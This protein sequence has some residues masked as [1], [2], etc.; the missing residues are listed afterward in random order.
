MTRDTT[1]EAYEEAKPKAPTQRELIEGFISAC[2]QTGATCD[3][4]EQIFKFTHQGASARVRELNQTNKIID[5]GDR[6]RTR[7]GRKAIVWIAAPKQM[8]LFAE[9]S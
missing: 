9:A 5:S 2:G 3:E 1:L 8:A 6:R 7:S 4:I